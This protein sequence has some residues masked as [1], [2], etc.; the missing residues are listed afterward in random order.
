MS[1]ISNKKSRKFIL[2]FI[3]L[4]LI[5]ISYVL[6]FQFRYDNI[7]PSN[8]EAFISLS[9][10]ILL[11][12]LFFITMYELYFLDQKG[13]WD[14][15]RKV[16]IATTLMMLF[17]MA[18]SFLF[19]EF[20]L[21][22]SVILISYFIINVLLISWKILYILLVTKKVGTILVV[23]DNDDQYKITRQIESQFGK[24]AVIKYLS[25]S[26]AMDSNHLELEQ[27][28][29]ILVSSK[30]PSQIKSNIINHS[31]KMDKIVYIVPDFYD[32][33]LSQSIVTT[34]DDSMVM[35]VKPFG[36][37]FGQQIVKRVY[38]IIVSL[39]SLILLSPI[40]IIISL[41]IKIEDP[42]GSVFYKQSRLGK[43]NKEFMI[44]KFRSMVEG[45]EKL[46]G[47]VLAEENDPRIT[48]IGKFMRKTRIDELPQLL[49]VLRGDMSIVGPRPEREFF[50]KQF[51]QEL[52]SYSY[53]NTVKPGITGYAQ[54][55]GKYTTSVDDKLRFDLFYIRNYSFILDMI[56]QFKTVSVLFDKTKAEGKVEN[57]NLETKKDLNLNS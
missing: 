49:N 38:D 46:S 17:T 31:I 55:M 9:P 30:I 51:E 5:F 21:P 43:N 41:I 22:R 56:I 4:C 12:G 44:Y 11:I 15:I 16:V 26:E 7:N 37:T 39:I 10:W 33:L 28:D 20:A 8:W 29:K 53:R 25:I 57:K 52:E 40:L 13:K 24:K 27:V 14:M 6:A 34:I 35:T 1:T 3:D 2:F 48:K 23:G 42:E 54:I 50:I 32:V 45:A 47:P 19:R 18:A 36:L